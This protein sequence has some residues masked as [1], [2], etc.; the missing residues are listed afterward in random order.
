MTV[1]SDIGGELQN[2]EEVPSTA[3]PHIHLLPAGDGLKVADLGELWDLF[4]F[5][6]PGLLS[7]LEDFNERFAFPIERY[8]DNQARNKLKKLIQPFLLRRT[9]TQVWKN[10]PPH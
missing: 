5:I 6:N 10:Y 7:S 8:Q 1:H 2:S 9:K 4:R 3:E